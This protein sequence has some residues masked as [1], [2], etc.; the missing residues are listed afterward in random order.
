MGPESPP[1]ARTLVPLQSPHTATTKVARN[2]LNVVL[3]DIL[4]ETWYPSFYP[5]ELVGRE[6]EKLYVCHF[7]FKYSKDVMMYVGHIVSIDAVV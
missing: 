3:G 1:N 6:T 7:C 2:V 5:E 4:F